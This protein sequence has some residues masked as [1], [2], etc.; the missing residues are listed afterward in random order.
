MRVRFLFPLMIV[1]LAFSAGCVRTTS[2]V[3]TPGGGSTLALLQKDFTAMDMREAILRACAMRQWRAFDVSANTIEA[4]TI[5]RG[6]QTVVVLIHY[7]AAHYYITHKSSTNM[8]YSRREDGTFSINRSYNTL[9]SNLD[10]AIQA[11][12]TQKT[13]M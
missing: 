2:N 5:I 7:S 12:I 4:K 8:G 6:R 1:L 9:V 13:A 11:H 10:Q 3:L